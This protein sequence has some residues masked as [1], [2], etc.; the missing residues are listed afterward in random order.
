MNL[1]PSKNITWLAIALIIFAIIARIIPHEYNFAPFG[2]IALFSA[3]YFANKTSGILITVLASWISGIILN[4][5]VY[6]GLYDHF[7]LIDENIFWQSLSYI[8]IVLMGKQLFNREVKAGSVILGALVSSI[9]F[10][11][12]TNFGF[13]FSALVHPR[14]MDGLIL[15]FRDALPFYR[16]TLIGDLF[17][18][19]ALFGSYF[20]IANNIG[21]RVP[22]T[23]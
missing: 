3:A 12:I 2:A 23:S 11:I 1:K 17:F 16:A 22:I 10:F 13:W 19:T 21:K 18:A 5:F 14:T 9:I 15:C 7:V 20:I 8:L 6:D 4:N